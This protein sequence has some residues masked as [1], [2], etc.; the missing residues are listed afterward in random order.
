MTRTPKW[1]RRVV[2]PVLVILQA[3]CATT[4]T[5]IPVTDLPVDGQTRATVLVDSQTVELWELWVQADTILGGRRPHDGGWLAGSTLQVPFSQVVEVRLAETQ[6]TP[7]GRSTLWGAGI[8]GAVGFVF[9]FMASVADTNSDLGGPGFGIILGTVLAIP[10][11]AV[12]ALIGAI[13][14]GD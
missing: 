14:G 11:A 5:P 3:A 10:G 9:G 1:A 6:L 13:A 8:G 4:L 2:V 12:G 7:R